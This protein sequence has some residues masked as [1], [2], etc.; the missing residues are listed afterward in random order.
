[1]GSR[2]ERRHPAVALVCA[3][4]L[5]L[6]GVVAD[7]PGVVLCTEESGSAA[8]AP[9]LCAA[10]TNASAFWM[11]AFIPLLVIAGLLVGSASSRRIVYLTVVMLTAQAA[12]LMMWLLVAHGTFHY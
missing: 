4:V 3:V 10:V 2:V 9:H 11:P 5:V 6:G 8:A 7:L 1:M 12:L